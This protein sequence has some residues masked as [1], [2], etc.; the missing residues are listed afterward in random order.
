VKC[1]RAFVI[2]AAA[3]LLFSAPLSAQVPQG[4]TFTYQGELRH[5]NAPV[6]ANVD[7]LFTLFDAA[8]N[9]TQLGQIPFA[10]PNAVAVSNGIFTV[11]LDFGGSFNTLISD[12]R[13]LEVTANGNI[14]SPR[15]QIQSAPYALQSQTAMLAYSISNASVGAA[16]IVPSQ[17]QARVGGSCAVGSSIRS[18]AQ[19]GTV[20]C[21]TNSGGGTVSSVATDAT[22]TGGPITTTGTLGIA[23]GAV[24]GAQINSS[25]VQ[26]RV[27]GSCSSGQMVQSVNADGSVNCAAASGGSGTVTNVATDATLTGGPISTSGTL[28]IAPGGVGLAQIDT[29][30]VQARVSGAC[31]PGEYMSG[32]NADGSVVCLALPSI[33]TQVVPPYVPRITSY[34]GKGGSLSAMALGSDGLPIISYSTVVNS[35][36]VLMVAKC[37]DPACLAPI[38]TTLF[39]R[40]PAGLFDP[41]V[42]GS[43]IT[44]GSD[45]LA[46]ISFVAAKPSTGIPALYFLKC[47]NAACT[48]T[49]INQ[50][51]IAALVDVSAAMTSPIT[52]IDSVNQ[53]SIMYLDTASNLRR[54]TCGGADCTSIF[55]TTTLASGV[56]PSFAG[57]IVLPGNTFYYAYANAA[58]SSHFYC[59]D[60]CPG[61]AVAFYTQTVAQPQIAIG[62]GQGSDI[63]VAF[64]NSAGNL[65][66]KDLTQT[67]LAIKVVDT[68][69]NVLAVSVAAST[70]PATIAYRNGNLI[71]TATCSGSS[72]IGSITPVLVDGLANSSIAVRVS[73]D[74]LPV[75]TYANGSELRV[76]K[77]TSTSCQ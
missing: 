34:W 53:V 31:A 17:V 55:N 57:A 33:P 59:S 19:D 50:S 8:S 52:L 35:N 45:G 47:A 27:A 26:K 38:I 39:D 14:L 4:T 66:L 70:G 61:G 42:G 41:A 51:S 5:N 21:Q 9:G 69:S 16:Q 76:A 73:S 13:W 67:S 54:S 28:G 72:C 71:K 75:L 7:M 10:G 49:T 29:S 65:S 48:A 60:S 12:Q 40:I 22:L 64:R 77:C 46:R 68:N 25:E 37:T 6:T 11:T 36:H 32:V 20:T 56:S 43:S 15:T 58:G 24:G 62:Y 63:F 1:I 74:N 2:L 18:I 23:P 44:V 30:K 3:W